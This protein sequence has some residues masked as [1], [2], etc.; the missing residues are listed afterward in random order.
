MTEDFS[1]FTCQGCGFRV[2]AS[3]MD[4]E[5]GTTSGRTEPVPTVGG[6]F[7]RIST[8]SFGR[9]RRV[10]TG[11]PRERLQPE[12]RRTPKSIGRRSSTA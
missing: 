3:A 5:I 6:T 2:Y 4:W 8:N 9:G 7:A 11:R 1:V 12:L 10:L